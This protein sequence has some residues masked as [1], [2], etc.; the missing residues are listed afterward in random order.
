VNG[1]KA[2]GIRGKAQR[3]K[4]RRQKEKGTEAEGGS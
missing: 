4:G 3:D 2:E 1:K